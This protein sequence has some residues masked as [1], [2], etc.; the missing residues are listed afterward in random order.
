M[1]NV[2]TLLVFLGLSAA[3]GLR[4]ATWYVD[5]AAAE[6]G[7]G[8]SW[9]TAFRKIPEGIEAAS[10]ADT[11]IVAEGAY[12]GCVWFRGPNI[13]VRS[14]DPLDPAVVASTVLDG[15]GVDFSGLEDDTCVL[16]G[17]TIRNATSPD[18]Y[19]FAG[20]GIYG[21][22]TRA[23]IS[24]N[25][26]TGN[27]ALESGG[28]LAFCDG[29]IED[30]FIT[31]NSAGVTIPGF[32]GGLYECNGVIRNNVIAGN[33][34]WD[35]W[36]WIGADGPTRVC[37]EG[38][39][40]HSCNGTIVNNTIFGNQACGGGGGLYGCHGT[41]RNNIIWA[42]EWAQLHDSIDPAYCCIQGWE[43]GGWMNIT[44]DPLFVDAKNGNFRLLPFSPC[45]GA[46]DNWAAHLP[47][48]DIAGMPRIMFGG[49][50]PTADIAAHIAGTPGIVLGKWRP[51]VDIGAYEFYR[52]EVKP[53]PG[54]EHTVFTWSSVAERTYS[55][56][57]TDDFFNWHTAIDK[58]PSSGNTTTSWIDDGSLTGLPP[59]LAPRR[60]YRLLQNP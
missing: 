19:P 18:T 44:E 41:I 34:A 26:I 42:N 60:F 5:G 56:F 11:V 49:W 52:N 35:G 2:R 16:S 39:G 4:A 10:E 8:T 14:R 27:E 31:D 36:V 20:G 1:L 47:E 29:I 13:T 32:G 3:T 58:F 53:V 28:G 54:T 30:N 48:T 24:H 55:I 21:R 15:C 46:G 6:S 7:D 43:G 23:T 45:I 9:A 22:G 40:L 57:Y 59:L 37:G 50:W 51:A 17:F 38:G 33:R 25:V 12:K